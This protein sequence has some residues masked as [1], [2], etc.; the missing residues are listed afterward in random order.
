MNRLTKSKAIIQINYLRT[1]IGKVRNVVVPLAPKMYWFNSLFHNYSASIA[2]ALVSGSVSSVASS[3]RFSLPSLTTQKA[4]NSKHQLPSLPYAASA[5]HPFLDARTLQLH[6]DIHHAE[7]VNGLNSTLAALPDFQDKTPEWLLLHLDDVPIRSRSEVRD[8]AGGHLNHS[9]MW[10]SMTPNP[11]STQRENAPSGKLANAI[12]L[13]FGNFENFK[14]RFE[15]MGV[16]LLGSGWVWL[17]LNKN[18]S[19]KLMTTSG[20]VNPISQDIDPLFVVDVWEHAYYLKYLN[21]RDKYLRAWW[22]VANWIEVETRY[23]QIRRDRLELP[24]IA[25]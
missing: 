2:P 6:H 4:R 18:G 9:M 13:S 15:E 20:H 1:L 8:N 17:V 5:L 16:K 24:A 19:L 23:D 21:R 22:S 25:N 10:R 11:K 3:S 12:D 7:Y 14:L